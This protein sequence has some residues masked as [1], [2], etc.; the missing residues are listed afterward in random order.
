MRS[1]DALRAALLSLVEQ[2]PLEQISIRDITAQA[3]LSYQVFFRRYASKEELLEDIATDE[4][5]RLLSLSRPMFE[6]KQHD[7]S[8]RALCDY[9]NE[10]RSLWTRLLTGGAAPAMR[11][12]FKR[13]AAEIGRGRERTNPWLPTDLAETF[14]VSGLFEIL[15]WWLRQPAD[16][17]V[18]N[19]VK[20]IDVLIVRATAEPVDI[21]LA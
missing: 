17:P 16:Y 3:G 15:S 20:I 18:E 7:E 10:H 19:V 5:R 14:V 2:R 4:V 11:R 21:Q 1:R 9:V 8:L 6:A 13:I 12:E